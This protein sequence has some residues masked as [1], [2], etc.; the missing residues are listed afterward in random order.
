MKMG[1]RKV[2]GCVS[3]KLGGQNNKSWKQSISMSDGSRERIIGR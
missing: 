3:S 2:G 1:E